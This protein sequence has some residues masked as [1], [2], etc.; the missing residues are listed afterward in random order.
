MLDDLLTKH[1]YVDFV[2]LQ[3]NYI[4][5]ESDGV[6]SRKCYEVARKHGKPI[7]VMEPVKGGALAGLSEEIQAMYKAVNPDL[8]I[9][10]WAVRFVASLDGLVTVLSG[11]VL[12]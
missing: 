8:S 10:S 2:Q 5:W 6:Q 1:P 12:S 4:D 7:I 9:P 11:H 3:L